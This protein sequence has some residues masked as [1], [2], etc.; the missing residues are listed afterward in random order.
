VCS[1]VV[2]VD[3]LYMLLL[4]QHI[5]NAWGKVRTQPNLQGNALYL[6]KTSPTPPHPT[7]PTTSPTM[8][9]KHTAKPAKPPRE[10]THHGGARITRSAE[11]IESGTGPVRPAFKAAAWDMQHCDPKRCSGKKLI[12]LGLMRD[13]RIGQKHAGVVLTPSGK[14]PVSP[15]DQGTLESYG[16]AVVECSWARLEEVPFARIGGRCERLCTY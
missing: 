13:L 14:I 1:C 8:P 6:P 15:A 3:V 10:R 9:K 4:G 7:S 11:A 5:Y 12:R 16:A 2:H